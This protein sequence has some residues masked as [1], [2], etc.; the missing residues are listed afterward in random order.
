VVTL[1]PRVV[2]QALS[3]AL[4]ASDGV[5]LRRQAVVSHLGR[6]LSVLTLRLERGYSDGV[7]GSVHTTTAAGGWMTSSRGDASRF[8]VTTVVVAVC[9]VAAVIA[10]AAW[11][12]ASL[13]AAASATVGAGYSRHRIVAITTSWQTKVRAPPLQQ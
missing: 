9:W 13:H 1:Q 6:L 3:F 8:A 12:A 7:D 11:T 2:S 4:V 5:S 10:L